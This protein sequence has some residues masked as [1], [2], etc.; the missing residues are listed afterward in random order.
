MTLYL[1]KQDLQLLKSIRSGCTTYKLPTCKAFLNT[2][3]A[4]TDYLLNSQACETFPKAA[5]LSQPQ[6][7]WK[8]FVEMGSPGANRDSGPFI[9]VR[10]PSFPGSKTSNRNMLHKTMPFSVAL[11]KVLSTEV[12]CK[13]KIFLWWE[14]L[15]LFVHCLLRGASSRSHWQNRPESLTW[16]FLHT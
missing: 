12:K 16:E 2:V 8:F 5:K 15:C 3:V 10:E 14:E 9:L 13:Y 11:Q 6:F 7:H 1:P 4:P